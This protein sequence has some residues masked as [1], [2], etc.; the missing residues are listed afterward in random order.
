MQEEPIL[1]FRHPMC[2]RCANLEEKKPPSTKCKAYPNG[3]PARHL[4]NEEPCGM[5][6]EMSET[7]LI[8][9]ARRIDPEWVANVERILAELDKLKENN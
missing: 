3:I 7:E 6:S 1:K 9:Q 8:E 4:V 5:F 2:S